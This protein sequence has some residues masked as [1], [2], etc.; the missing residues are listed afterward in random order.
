MMVGSVQNGVKIRPPLGMCVV[1][2]LSRAPSGVIGM[3]CGTKASP[4]G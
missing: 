2:G 3:S 4:T 1:P